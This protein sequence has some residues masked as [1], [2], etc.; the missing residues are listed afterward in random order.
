MSGDLS[1]LNSKELTGE[2]A[3]SIIDA[4][5]EYQDNLISTYDDL[6]AARKNIED[7]LFNQMNEYTEKIDQQINKMSKLSVI[8]ENIKTCFQRFLLIFLLGKQT[9]P[10][11][12]TEVY[13]DLI[14]SN[15]ATI[16]DL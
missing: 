10:S 12:M 4:L 13:N 11:V 3:Q 8:A 16:S 2:N 5:K 1:V 15:L 9:F 14:T 6:A 7:E